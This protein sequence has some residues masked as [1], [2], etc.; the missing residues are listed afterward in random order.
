MKIGRAL[1]QDNKCINISTEDGVNFYELDPESYKIFNRVKIRK[2]LAPTV[3]TKVVCVGLNYIDH[4]R[5]LGLALPGE[6]LL[7]I[8]PPS[9]VIAHNDII[10]YP[11]SS[12]RVDFEAELAVIIKKTC[13]K[14]GAEKARDY[15]LGYSCLNDVTARDLQVSDGQWTRA[16][17]FNTFC[18][19][20]PFIETGLENPGNLEIKLFLNSELKQS[21]NTSNLIFNVY[22]IV[23][24]ISN[25]MTLEAGD[26]IATGTPAGIGEMQRGDRVQVEIESIGVLENTVE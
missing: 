22:E 16:K 7:F 13:S 2:I 6:P 17:S 1:N 18:P 21:S 8:K 23:S 4:A 3:P 15:I 5:E 12:N 26:V 14:T 11:D 9:S 24:Y 10:I 20:G 19:I 25:I